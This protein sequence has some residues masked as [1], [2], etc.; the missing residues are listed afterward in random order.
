MSRIGKM[1]ISLPQGVSVS[2]EEC[3]NEVNIKGPKGELSHAIDSSINVLVKDEQVFL[4]RKTDSK[5]H[6]AFHGL[7]RSLLNNMVKGVSD[8]FTKSLELVGVGY[9][10]SFTKNFLEL[11]LGYSHNIIFVTPPEVNVKVESAK[12]KNPIITIS[13]MDLQLVG[14]VA[15]KIRSLRKPEPYKGKGIR[16]V[17]EHIKLKVGKAAGKK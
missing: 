5:Q 14:Q 16:F 2:F 10:A 17:G 11:D 12:G 15:A 3:N 13:G 9:K 7:Y 6:K 8:G 4:T 1:P